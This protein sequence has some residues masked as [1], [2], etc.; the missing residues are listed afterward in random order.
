ME[1]KQANTQTETL[2]QRI[3][4]KI[5]NPQFYGF[6]ASIA[7]L[8]AISF[9]YFYPDV[10]QG[11]ELRQYDM[12]Q[13]AANG[14]EAKEYFEATGEKSLWT[15]SLFSG[16]PTFQ[17]SPYY[18]SNDLFSWIN[19]IMGF[20]LPAP[21]N[22]L[23]MMMVGF[24]ILMFAFKVRWY[25]AVIGAIAYGFS[26]Y[27]IILIGAGHIW[28]FITLAYIPPTIAGIVLC[29]R[30][31][32]L[33]GGALAAL[34]AMMQ[35]SSNHVQMSY[36]F[37]FVIVGLVIA[38]LIMALR[39]KQLKQW[40]IATGTLMIAAI[41]AVTANLPSLYN[42][43][44]YSK[45]TMRGKHS[46]L[47]T[48]QADNTGKK[49]SGL[50]KDYIM[51][52]SYTPSET[53]TLLIPNVK[54]GASVKPEQGRHKP[55]TLY[56]LPETQDLINKGEIYSQEAANL[57]AF[58][59]YFGAPEGTNGPVY[60]GALIFA[61]FLLGCIIVRGPIKWILVALTLL[62]IFLAWGRYME[63]FT[64]LFIDYIPMYNKFRT[65][66]SI[67]VIAEF[68]MPL[69]GILALH[70]LFTTPQFW[71]KY[72]KSIYAAF[73]TALFFCLLGILSP[74][75]FG[76]YLGEGEQ[77][78]ISEGLDKQFP[79]LFSA[80]EALRYSMVRSDALR[81]FIFIAAGGA[82]LLLMMRRKIQ[83]WGAVAIIFALILGDLYMVNKRYLNHDSFCTPELTKADPFPLR[84][85]DRKIL[86]D[87]AMNY[88][89][90]DLQNFGS[91]SPSYHHK[92]VGG[93]H[94]AKLTRYQDMISRHIG[95][96]S[97][98]SDIN[99]LNMLNTKYIISDAN[100]VEI[101]P[102]ALGN[103]WWVENIEYADNANAEMAALDTIQPAIT[104]VADVKFK[105]ILGS[106]IPQKQPGDTIFET[107]YA[108]NKLTYH[109]HSANGGLAVFSEVYF[110]WGWKATIDGNPVEIGRVN[111]L[112]R[113]LRVPAGSHT[114]EMKFDPDSIHNTVNAA[115][116]AIILIYV[117]L[118]GAAVLALTRKPE[119]ENTTAT[120]ESY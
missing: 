82:V 5:K 73:G 23:F 81:S 55:L 61:L 77:G 74:G 104:A 56:D 109:A 97:N 102:E 66:E 65:V 42:T 39:K 22:L 31:R 89:V 50:D 54:G 49:S 6:I 36:Y 71:N 93:Y 111:Y 86:T 95:R 91:P 30:G 117:A 118:M 90:L 88:R 29:Y 28:K 41:L 16:M 25:F 40:S 63:W 18:E 4:S 105:E 67:L 47:V 87:T 119:Q 24:L 34:F 79:S 1:Q 45:E 75:I 70:K 60:V 107:T 9:F 120:D 116:I 33:L 32:Y 19:D 58:S 26:S 106:E 68:T 64:M 103:A 38:Y 114:I 52:Y 57:Q 62:S 15:N 92:M 99:V 115:R 53:F 112:L 78:Y 44:E 108:P 11:N 8:V 83:A 113:A 85:A 37:L 10:V 96:L 80:V 2:M 20:G 3:V 100:T 110:P 27:F 35:I 13:G 17:I 76:S 7:I 46:D 98:E 59:Q 84:P 101:N 43:Y 48:T 14:Q 12:Q 21:A 72:A 69:L 51:G 94:A